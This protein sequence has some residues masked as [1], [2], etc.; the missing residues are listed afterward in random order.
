M[1]FSDFPVQLWMLHEYCRV[2]KNMLH[3]ILI[4]WSLVV[5][6]PSCIAVT[7]PSK[8]LTFFFPHTHFTTITTLICCT[9]LFFTGFYRAMLNFAATQLVLVLFWGGGDGEGGVLTCISIG[10][11]ESFLLPSIYLPLSWP[12]SKSPHVAA[13]LQ[14]WVC[15]G[16]L[17]LFWMQFWNEHTEGTGAV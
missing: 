15:M 17:V 13:C 8:F 6:F 5:P 9:R 3:I 10:I 1:I 7:L 16:K 11:Q 12:G 14:I 4:Q 2:R